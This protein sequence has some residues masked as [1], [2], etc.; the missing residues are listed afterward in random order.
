MAGIEAIGAPEWPPHVSASPPGLAPI[1]R[2]PKDEQGSR[3]PV[4][5]R[6][7][8]GAS[9]AAKIR[10]NG[11]R[12][13]LGTHPAHPFPAPKAAG[14]RPPGA[15]ESGALRDVRQGSGTWPQGQRA[16]WCILPQ[17]APDGPAEEDRLRDGARPP[18]PVEAAPRHPEMRARWRSAAGAG[19]W[20]PDSG[21]ELT[22]F[23]NLEPAGPCRPRARL[24][25]DACPTSAPGP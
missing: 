10:W 17:P 20:H 6:P 21:P 18:H 25:A 14:S 5:P 15:T 23:R 7:R 4:V 13:F 16:K 3:R 11:P 22:G 2:F 12:R 19:P 8:S 24:E 9:S 1:A